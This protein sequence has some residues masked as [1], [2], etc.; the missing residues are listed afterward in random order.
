MSLL[1]GSDKD[2]FDEVIQIL[3]TLLGVNDNNIYNL[4]IQILKIQ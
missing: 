2:N 3:V 4:L 1:Q